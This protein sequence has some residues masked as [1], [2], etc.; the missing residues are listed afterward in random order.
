MAGLLKRL[1]ARGARAVLGE[2]GAVDAGV[3]RLL[4]RIGTPSSDADRR[5]AAQELRDMVRGAVAVLAG[6]YPSGIPLQRPCAPTRGDPAPPPPCRAFCFAPILPQFPPPPPPSQVADN[7]NA[8]LALGA[9]GLPVLSAVLRDDRTDVALVRVRGRLG[10]GGHAQCRFSSLLGSPF[11]PQHVKLRDFRDAL[12]LD[13]RPPLPPL[14]SAPFWRP[15]STRW[16]RASS[17]PRPPA[18]SPPAPSMRS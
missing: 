5:S 14:R 18:T 16:A 9:M 7:P 3:E 11:L 4:E 6:R 13:P 15:F 1:A 17:A 12:Q 8:Q 10:G 2:P